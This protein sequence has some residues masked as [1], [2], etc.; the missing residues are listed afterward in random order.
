MR[1]I[2]LAQPGIA[3][4]IGGVDLQSVLNREDACPQ[5][6][7]GGDIVCLRPEDR[8]GVAFLLALLTLLGVKI[9]RP[10]L[11]LCYDLRLSSLLCVSVSVSESER[12]C[13]VPCWR[14]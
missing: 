10:V 12:V 3:V 8:L 9:Q 11:V 6:C 2:G 7:L 5:A 4:A 13:C 14:G 1:Q